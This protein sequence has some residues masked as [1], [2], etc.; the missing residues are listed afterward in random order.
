MT[1]LVLKA[2]GPLLDV[3][4]SVSL[5]PGGY[6]TSSSLFLNGQQRH[7]R[8]GGLGPISRSILVYFEEGETFGN[9][10]TVT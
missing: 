7:Q 9:R 2:L 10:D 5:C 8:A 6:R 4:M 1:C 3:P